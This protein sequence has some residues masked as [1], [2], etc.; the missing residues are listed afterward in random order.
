MESQ[1]ESARS[2]QLAVD[3]KRLTP[4]MA[5]AARKKESLLLARTRLLDQIQASRYPRHREMLETALADLDKTLARF[6]TPQE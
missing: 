4:E 5:E 2:D 6:Q 1:I 3:H